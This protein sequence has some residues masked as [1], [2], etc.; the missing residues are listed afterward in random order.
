MG[1][2]EQMFYHCEIGNEIDAFPVL[3]PSTRRLE[4]NMR[5]LQAACMIWDCSFRPF[6]YGMDFAYIRSRPM[7]VEYHSSRSEFNSHSGGGRVMHSE[8]FGGGQLTLPANEGFGA[9]QITDGHESDGFDAEDA[10]ARREE[11]KQERQR[12][13]QEIEDKRKHEEKIQKERRE[14]KEELARK[15]RKEERE[16]CDNKHRCAPKAATEDRKKRGDKEIAEEKEEKRRRETKEIRIEREKR[17]ARM[18]REER[19]RNEEIE[20]V[21]EK[22]RRAEKLRIKAMEERNERDTKVKLIQFEKDQEKTVRALRETDFGRRRRQHDYEKIQKLRGG[23]ATTDDTRQ[24]R[25][26]SDRALELQGS[27]AARIRDQA[28][29]MFD[30]FKIDSSV[31]QVSRGGQLA[32]ADGSGNDRDRGRRDHH[33]RDTHGHNDNSHGYAQ[34]RQIAA[35]PSQADVSNEFDPYDELGLLKKNKPTPDEIK[36][37]WKDMCFRHHPD[38]DTGKTEAQIERSKRRIVGV[39]RAYDILSDPDRKRAY[40]EERIVQDW[41]FK[42]WQDKRKGGGSYRR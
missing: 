40:D 29:G 34:T 4:G 36:A 31:G 26:A 11:Q 37:T 42:E 20:E 33:D 35:A 13:K 1:Q 2:N 8:G 38:K 14:E 30:E 41:L 18:A 3:G 23:D 25:E 21:E 5:C 28:D 15:A 12:S 6:T 27:E 32:I 39:N 10:A 24:G 7:F 16:L 22:S 19:E 17:E 9:R